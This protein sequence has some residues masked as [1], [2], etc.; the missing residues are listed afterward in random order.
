MEIWGW[1]ILI[2][3]ALVIGFAAQFVPRAPT[4]YDWLITAVAAG[5][6]AFIGSELLGSFSTWGPEMFGLYI[7]PALIGAIVM[8]VVVDGVER[9]TY[10]PGHPA[11]MA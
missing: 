2:V 9:F 11:G 6:G 4:M 8:A 3:G 10:H 7:L 5:I 1:A